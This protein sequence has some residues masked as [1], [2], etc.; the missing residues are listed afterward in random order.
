MTT[1]LASIVAPAPTTT[2]PMSLAPLPDRHVA[3]HRRPA[4]VPGSQ[5][6][7]DG[8]SDPGAVAD[9]HEPVDHHLA[10]TM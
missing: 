6:D 2:S 10:V 8:R 5:A 3:S 7:L 9:I 1:A 4:R